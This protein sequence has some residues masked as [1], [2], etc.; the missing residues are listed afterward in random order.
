MLDQLGETFRKLSIALCFVGALTT[1]YALAFADIPVGRDGKPKPP[2]R[3]QLLQTGAI[4]AAGLPGVVWGF[5][6]YARRHQDS[7]W[8]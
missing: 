2:L 6:R 5:V 8:G 1:F 7:P 3:V 4:F